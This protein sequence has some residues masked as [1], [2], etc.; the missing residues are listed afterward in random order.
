MILKKPYAFFIKMFKPVH[1]IL[2]VLIAYLIYLDNNILKFLNDYIYTSNNSIGDNIT[3]KLISNLLYIIPFI[4]IIMSL[5]ILGVMYKKK[6]HITFYV[7]NIFVFIVVIVINLYASNFLE[8]LKE[9]VVSIKSA[10]LIHDLVLINIGIQILSFIFFVVRGVG[11]NFKKFDFAS[12]LSKIDIN[13]SDKEEFELN[14]NVDINENRRRRR[15]KIRN[16]KYFYF[17]NKFM[18]NLSGLLVLLISGI[19]AYFIIGNSNENKKEGI[20]YSTNNFEFGVNSTTLLNTDYKGNKITDNYLIVVDCKIK[21]IY[22]SN[23]LYLN[24]FSL[25]IGETVFKPTTK[26]SNSL[27]DLGLSYNEEVLLKEYVN[28]LFVF[29][30]PEKYIESTMIFRYNN[31]G[32]IIGIKLKPKNILAKD[33]SVSKKVGEEISFEET[34]G[35]I[36]FKVNNYDIKDK[37]LIE[38]DYCV[39]EDDCL[40]S[41]E[42][43]KASIDKNFDKYILKLNVEYNENSNLDVNTF[44]KFFSKFASIHYNINGTWYSQTSDFEEIKSNKLFEKNIA[45]IGIDSKIVNASNIKLIFNVRDSKYEYIIK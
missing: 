8:V 16:L 45:Y 14:I 5:L 33:I 37:F 29:E 1:L 42:Y 34:L 12:E 25:K 21:S 10:K 26:Y 31:I 6:K 7:F 19:C 18:I 3:E 40:K 28:Y 39:K 23:S 9:S 32:N 20:V 35:D 43:L 44:Y 15:K 38:Y 17:E 11:I 36:K 13:E 22:D 2:S 41:K 4:L 30:I 24:D 27:V